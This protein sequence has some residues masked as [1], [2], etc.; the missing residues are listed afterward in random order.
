MS[1]LLAENLQ[2]LLYKQKYIYQKIKDYTDKFSSNAELYFTN[3]QFPNLVTYD[4]YKNKTLFYNEKEVKEKS[5]LS[6]YETLKT[7][8]RDVVMLGFGLSYH[9]ADLMELNQELQFYIYEPRIDIFIEALKV[10]K[11]REVIEHHRVKLFDI[12]NSVDDY[13]QFTVYK[14]LNISGYFYNLV[15]PQ[16]ISIAEEE[17]KEFIEIDYSN[18]RSAKVVESFDHIFGTLPYRNSIRNLKHVSN[19]QSL[20]VLKGKLKGCTALIVGSGPSLEKDI[21][22]IKK[23]K[24]K[25]LIIAAGSAIQSL[26]HYG[27]TPHL[28]VSID[29]GETNG[30][31]YESID[32]LALPMVFTLQLFTPILDKKRDGLFYINTDSEPLN[33]AV[34]DDIISPTLI[35]TPSVS[36]TSLQIAHFVGATSIILVGQDVSFPNNNYYASGAK[37]IDTSRLESTVINADMEIEN[38]QGGINKTNMSMTL[39]REGLESIIKRLGNDETIVYNSSSL[40]A[41]IEG[42]EYRPLEDIL[43]ENS[44]IIYDF[45]IIKNLAFNRKNDLDFRNQII[46][47]L[48]DKSELIDQLMT[49]CKNVS[50]Q[51]SKFEIAAR[52][53]PQIANN[54]LI[55][56]EKLVSDITENNFFKIFLPQWAGPLLREYD[57]QIQ[58][59]D[60]EPNMIAKSKLLRDILLPFVEQLQNVFLE[61]S[62]E[63]NNVKN[64]I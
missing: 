6:D 12:G 42:A 61:I 53:N 54:Q 11:I 17:V 13:K 52:K 59:V 23:Y 16:Y 30:K 1:D 32:Y 48:S 25:V 47:K 43:N 50:K 46:L 10:V 37:H 28:I 22:T 38:V 64:E 24:N 40:G 57:G 35:A 58:L 44:T 26:L 8:Y 2:Y 3:E 33:P 45:S 14:N 21:K 7:G 36:G 63:I 62:K 4:E 19:S 56:L 29:P 41:V 5:W 55:K 31:V 9:L 49:N 18:T 20:N 51:L 27:I 60:L 15:V 39:I 34:L